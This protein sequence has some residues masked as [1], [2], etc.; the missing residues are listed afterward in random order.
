MT[1]EDLI[2]T[3]KIISKNESKDQYSLL[4]EALEFL[5]VYAGEKSAF[6]KQLDAKTKNLPSN[7]DSWNLMPST[8]ISQLVISH[9]DAFIRY[10]ENGLL[11]GVSIKRQAEIDIVS[12]ILNQAKSLL[13][14]KGVHPA[15]A[16]VLSGAVLEEFL[17]IWADEQ[18]LNTGKSK[19]SI[20]T[21][22]KVLYENN[23]I[24]KQDIKDITAWGGLR[25]DAAHG[26]WDAV[27]DKNK[28]ELMLEGVNLFMRKYGKQGMVLKGK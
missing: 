8:S 3:A 22:S 19:P 21:Y 17:R 12:D 5:R 2:K 27:S 9:L 24:D 10:A 18:N 7:E 1:A 15:S 26:K 4:A 11:H 14:T 6:Y 28:I 25:N 16:C 23:L 20:D 13:N